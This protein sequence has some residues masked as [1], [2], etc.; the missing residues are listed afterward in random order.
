MWE[1]AA[2]YSSIDLN[3]GPIH[4]GRLWRLTGVLKWHASRRV[5]TTFDY[6]LAHLDRDGLRS[7]THIFQ[8]RLLLW[9]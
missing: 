2:R 4:G 8:M 5:M 7:Y 3:D 6:G 1:V 9:F